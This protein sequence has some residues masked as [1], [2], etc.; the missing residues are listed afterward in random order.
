MEFFSADFFAALAAIIVIDLVLAGDNAI[1]IALAARNLP[2][3]LRNRAIVWGTLGA[4]LVR[5]AMTLVVVWLLRLPGLLALGGLALVWIAVRLLVQDEGEGHES[6]AAQTFWGAMK[7]IVVADAVMGLDNVL[8]VAGAAHGSFL[9]VVLGL[10]ISIPIVI[11]GSKLILAWVDR[12]PAI[13]YLGAGVLA[14]TAATMLLS[15]PLLREPIA[16]HGWIRGL[17]YATILSGVLGGG[18]FLNYR[19][20]RARVVRHVVEPGSP[21]IAEAARRRG[22]A[23]KVL[24]PVDGSVNALRAVRHVAGQFRAGAPLEVHLLTVT[25]PLSRHVARFFSRGDLADYHQEQAGRALGG[26]RLE[27]DRAGVP[28][29]CH[30]ERGPKAEAI[31]AAAE[32]LDVDHIVVGTARRNSLT[33]LVQDSVTGNLLRLTKVPVEVIVGDDVAGFERYGVPAGAVAVVAVTLAA[34]LAG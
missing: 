15:E 14:W 24:V 18:F 27:L 11:W 5:T 17:A 19:P 3:R 25:V 6:A 31:N 21:A 8:A 33:R 30:V 32:R 2:A 26:A 4:I 16:G 9:L 1:V 28:Y 22:E 29:T 23:V 34:I 13:I 7:T 20:L 12:F 10:L